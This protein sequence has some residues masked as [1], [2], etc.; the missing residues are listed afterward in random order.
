MSEIKDLRG[1]EHRVVGRD[2]AVIISGREY[3][4]R[5]HLFMKIEGTVLRLGTAFRANDMALVGREL[6]S[7]EDLLGLKEFNG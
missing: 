2:D 5:G 3:L 4:Q 6:A 1:V 7:L